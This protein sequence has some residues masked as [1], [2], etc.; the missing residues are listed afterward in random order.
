MKDDNNR[1]LI[2]TTS[3]WDNKGGKRIGIDFN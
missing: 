3:G 1:N 2:K